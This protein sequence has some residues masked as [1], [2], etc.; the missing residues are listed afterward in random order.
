MKRPFVIFIS[1]FLLTFIFLFVIEHFFREDIPVDNILDSENIE[2]KIPIVEE[3]K[4]DLHF[5]MS[6]IGDI[7]CH[8]SQYKDAY[9]SST[10][11]YDFSYVFKD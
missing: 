2:N 7:M 4:E 6:V 5:S 9:N 10:D 1:I 8:N 11:T 3:P